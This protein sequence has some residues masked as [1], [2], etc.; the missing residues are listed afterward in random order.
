MKKCTLILIALLLLL[1]SC[2][3]FG[4]KGQGHQAI[5]ANKVHLLNGSYAIKGLKSEGVPLNSYYA[6]EHFYR[7]F[8]RDASMMDTLK[9]DSV[10]LAYFT[11]NIIDQ[12]TLSVSFYKGREEIRTQTLR[13]KLKDGDGF[14]YLKHKNVHIK[15]LPHI[16][17][18]IDIKKVRIGLNADNN[19]MINDTYYRT[20]VFMV[21]FGASSRGAFLL[22]YPRISQ[23]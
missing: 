18:S 1:G 7:N 17:G 21:L 5:T 12:Q 22:E 16:A 6:N 11:L 4:K 9:W 23:Q 20:W 14:I 13:Y 15:G 10:G 19:L 3:P 8:K 2:A